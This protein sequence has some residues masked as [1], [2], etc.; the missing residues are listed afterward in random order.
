M[1]FDKFPITVKYHGHKATAIKLSN[2]KKMVL[3]EYGTKKVWA[4]LYEIDLYESNS[5]I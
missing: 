5:N 2:N 3:L 1:I 4:Y